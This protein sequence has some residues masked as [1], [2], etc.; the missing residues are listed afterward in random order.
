MTSPTLL[1]DI[2]FILEGFD[3]ARSDFKLA[4]TYQCNVSYLSIIEEDQER[5]HFLLHTVAKSKSS[6]SGKKSMRS[7]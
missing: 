4:N 1:K 3:F 7:P 5:S 6:P 2:E